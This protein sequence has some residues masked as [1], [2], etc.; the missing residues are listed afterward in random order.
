MSTGPRGAAPVPLDQRRAA[1]DHRVERPGALVRAARWCR[2]QLRRRLGGRAPGRL[3]EPCEQHRGGGRERGQD[4]GERDRSAHEAPPSPVL[5]W[6]C[7]RPPSANHTPAP[8]DVEN[9]RPAPPAD[10]VAGDG[11]ARLHKARALDHRLHPVPAPAAH[12]DPQG[13]AAAVQ[14]GEHATGA[15]AAVDEVDARVPEVGDAVAQPPP[16]SVPAH[17]DPHAP[18]SSAR[19]VRTPAIAKAGR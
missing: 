12:A 4:G 19:A 1:D 11:P 9:G 5:A 13:P 17:P 2:N 14:G 15:R 8:S 10:A 16:T 7:T 6:P 3:R 18:G